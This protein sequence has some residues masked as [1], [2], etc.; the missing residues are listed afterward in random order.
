MVWYVCGFEWRSRQVMFELMWSSSLPCPI[1]DS[2]SGLQGLLE[3]FGVVGF[4]GVMWLPSPEPAAQRPSY[5]SRVGEWL[6]SGRCG[7]SH[8]HSLFLTHTNTHTHTHKDTHT[9]T[10]TLAIPH[11]LLNIQR[12][13]LC[14]SLV[15]P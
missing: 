5:Q 2:S 10:H 3:L 6:F 13:P 7:H 1:C 8:T 15:H 12:V 9:C 11:L 14:V 4:G